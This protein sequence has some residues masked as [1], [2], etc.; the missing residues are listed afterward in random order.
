VGQ[1]LGLVGS[2]RFAMGS[3][4]WGHIPVWERRERNPLPGGIRIAQE[5]HERPGVRHDN[6]FGLRNA[7]TSWKRASDLQGKIPGLGRHEG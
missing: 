3:G 2:M 4:I 1:D 6:D 7:R 5:Y